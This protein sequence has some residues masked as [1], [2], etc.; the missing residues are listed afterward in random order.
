[1]QGYPG[2]AGCPG[3]K[4]CPGGYG[5]RG[6]PGLQGVIGPP[7]TTVTQIRQITSITESVTLNYED[8]ALMVDTQGGDVTINLPLSYVSLIGENNF[9]QYEI[10]KQ[11]EDNNIRIVI[12][13]SGTFIGKSY[14][15]IWMRS[16]GNTIRITLT[17][18]GWGY[19][20]TLSPRFVANF[21]NII[22]V[23]VPLTPGVPFEITGTNND[24]DNPE[25]FG[26]TVDIVTIRR[27]ARYDIHAVSSLFHPADQLNGAFYQINLVIERGLNTISINDSSTY[28][29]VVPNQGI[30]VEVNALS[31][32]LLAGDI[33]RMYIQFENAPAD[34]YEIRGT[35]LYVVYV[36]TY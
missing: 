16:G 24:N 7:G 29:V 10:T 9:K 32:E 11:Y 13:D 12:S 31:Y 25:I 5:P 4:G 33:I 3:V 20:G 14:G 30:Y 8:Q 26:T 6:L 2:E 35:E 34:E 21:P 27:N 19:F 15:T 17:Q 36:D 18:N 22:G 1:M 28:N 23:P